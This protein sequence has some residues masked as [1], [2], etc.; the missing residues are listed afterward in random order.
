MKKLVLA[1]AASITLAGC[2]HDLVRPDPSR[3]QCD[4]A[5]VVP[6][7]PVTDEDNKNYL[8]ALYGS[9]ENCHDAILWLRDYFAGQN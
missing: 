5:P 9:W 3:L 7:E 2:A 6:D 8:I 4:G 1:A